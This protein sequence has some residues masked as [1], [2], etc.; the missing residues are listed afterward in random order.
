MIA[1]VAEIAKWQDCRMA[2][3]EMVDGGWEL[4]GD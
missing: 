3:F 2:G 4:I 1:S